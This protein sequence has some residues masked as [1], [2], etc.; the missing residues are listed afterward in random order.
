MPRLS[1]EYK[2]AIRQI[3][4]DDD[5]KILHFGNQ[6]SARGSAAGLP[7]RFKSIPAHITRTEQTFEF[8]VCHAEGNLISQSK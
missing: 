7:L 1:K 5:Q 8:C 6:K 2:D 4:Q 3:P